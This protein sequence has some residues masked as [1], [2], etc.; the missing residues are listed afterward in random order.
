MSYTRYYACWLRAVISVVWVLGFVGLESAEAK[1]QGSRTKASSS[2]QTRSTKQSG[3]SKQTSTVKSSKSSSSRRSGRVNRSSSQ[4]RRSSSAVSRASQRSSGSS[5]RSRSSSRSSRN[6]SPRQASNNSGSSSSRQ[7]Y[8]HSSSRTS[9]RSSSSR[10]DSTVSGTPQHT[11]PASSGRSSRNSRSGSVSSVKQ[12]SGSSSQRVGAQGSSKSQRSS[13][14]RVSRSNARNYTRQPSSIISRSEPGIQ[15]RSG[16]RLDRIRN[17]D[18]TPDTGI[19]DIRWSPKERKTG[20]TR[21]PDPLVQPKGGHIAA[22]VRT[23]GVKLAALRES[24][25][26][27]GG[28]RDRPRIATVGRSGFDRAQP[29]VPPRR[30]AIVRRSKVV[31]H[32]D[33][34]IIHP[35][36]R[37]IYRVPVYPSPVIFY[38]DDGYDNG[39]YA[40]AMSGYCQSE[41]DNGT[42][43]GGN[44]YI[45]WEAEPYGGCI[46]YTVTEPDYS[47][48][49]SSSSPGWY[50]YSAPYYGWSRLYRR[51]WFRCVS[52]YH[53]YR[54]RYCWDQFTDYWWRYGWPTCRYRYLWLGFGF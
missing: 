19:P 29:S 40:D 3:A 54:L 49:V 9:K 21:R 52:P 23:G 41:Y 47:I 20:K 39:Y 45:D 6:S 26:S 14:I 25:D 51:I 46:E 4:E 53:Y 24:G 36:P 34:R 2:K 18:T 35:R 43:Y 30:P 12:P 5:I 1:K 11:S 31:I 33:I 13:G 32:K 8:S 38:D 50:A 22:R 28:L 42:W 27:A 16:V 17:S 37:V 7:S 10:S 15:T 44:C 48:C